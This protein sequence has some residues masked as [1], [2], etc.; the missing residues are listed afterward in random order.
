VPNNDA[1]V[2][3]PRHTYSYQPLNYAD[4]NQCQ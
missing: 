2:D 4:R 1:R 3:N